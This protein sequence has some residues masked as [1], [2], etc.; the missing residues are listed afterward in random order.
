[1][2][3]RRTRSSVPAD[4]DR[5]AGGIFIGEAKSM[6]IY[7]AV[8]E[9]D[10][11]VHLTGSLITSGF[12][13][14][15]FADPASLYEAALAAPCDIAVIDA[16]IRN[17]QG[18]SILAVLRRSMGAGIIALLDNAAIETRLECLEYGAD[19][20]VARSLDARELIAQLRALQR[21]L[22]EVKRPARANGRHGWALDDDGW[23]LRAPGGTTLPLTTAERA[24]FVRLCQKPGRPVSRAELMSSLGVD[25]NR[26][27]PHRIDV[28]VNRL[29]RKASSFNVR[30]PLHSVRGKGYALTVDSISSDRP[31]VLARESNAEFA[32]SLHGMP[33]RPVASTASH[34]SPARPSSISSAVPVAPDP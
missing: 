27:D 14:S 11:R 25:P 33:R 31:A 22:K 23:V 13:V 4:A 34:P 12:R 7:L 26:G 28:L 15:S 9:A 29:R 3:G 10:L 18:L 5:N 32:S 30:L 8:G 24:F 21:R 17:K 20:C 2:G 19:A 16:S 1:L 6:N